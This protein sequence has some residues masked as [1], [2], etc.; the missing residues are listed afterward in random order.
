MTMLILLPLVEY[1]ASLTRMDPG[2]L[3]YWKPVTHASSQHAHHAATSQGTP[4][5]RSG[6]CPARQM[7]A[8]AW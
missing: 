5:R 4:A 3:V 7:S 6:G 2:F 8:T 1:R